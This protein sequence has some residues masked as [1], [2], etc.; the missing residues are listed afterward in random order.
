ML[1]RGGVRRRRAIAAAGAVVIVV[2]VL[3][4][5]LFVLP[6]GDEPVPADAVVVLA[7]RGK[8]L[9]RGQ[10][11][12]FDGWAE[13]L[14]LSSQAP[15]NCAPDPGVPTQYCFDPDPSTT[16]GEARAVAELVREHGWRTLLVV[17]GNEQARRAALRLDRCLP[18]GVDVRIVTVRGSILGSLW[19]AVYE[20]GALAK[21]ALVQRSC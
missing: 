2:L 14:V 17:A 18:D 6:A 16:R 21:A 1:R 8:R 11:L 10:Q 13:T 4:L 19:Q 20:T 15:E 9:E 12:I 5:W 3:E 7:G